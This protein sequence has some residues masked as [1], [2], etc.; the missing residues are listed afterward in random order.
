MRKAWKYPL[1]SSSLLIAILCFGCGSARKLKDNELLLK[2]NIVHASNRDLNRDEINTYIRQKPNRKLFFFYPFYLEIYNLVNQDKL[3]KHK[4][5]RDDR[6][7]LVNE[8]RR[9]RNQNINE[10]RRS[11]NKP[12]KPLH[13]K[14]K[15]RLTFRE[16]LVNI[17]EEPTLFDSTLANRSARQ[18]SLY[19]NNK[20]YFNNT[21]RDSIVIRNNKAKVYYL[22]KTPKAYKIRKIKYD[23]DDPEAAYYVLADSSN[24]LLKPGQNVDSDVL[25]K[26]RDRITKVL[27]NEGYFYFSKEY[28]YYTLDSALHTRQADITIGL[29]KMSRPGSGTDSMTEVNHLRYTIEH[30]YILTDY[31]SKGADTLTRD[32]L[33][34]K[35]GYSFLYANK[36]HYK[37]KIISDAIYFHEGE[38]YQDQKNDDTYKRLV[39]LKAF[40]QVQIEYIPSKSSPP[41]ELDCFIRLTP[42]YKQ[43]IS[44]GGE[45]TNTGGNLGIN[46]SIVYQNKNVLKGAEVFELKAKGALELQ[47]LVVNIGSEQAKKGLLPFN[48]IELGPEFNLYVP[49]ALFPFNLF[50]I[51]KSANPKTTFTSYYNFQ[52][53]PDYTRSIFN[54]GYAYEW[55]EGKYK[56]H[57]ILPFEVNLVK[58]LK[59]DPAFQTYLNSYHDFYLQSRYQNHVTTDTRWTYTFTN[60]EIKKKKDYIFFRFDLESSGTLLRSLAE[61]SNSL[62]L[63][64]IPKDADGS[65][66]IEQI[67]FS[68]YIKGGYDLRLYKLLTEYNRVIFRTFAGLGVPFHNLSTLPFEKSYYAGGPNDVRAF[69]ARSL[70]PGSYNHADGSVYQLGDMQMEAN[71]EYRYK[72]FKMLNAAFFV[73]AGNIW[74]LKNDPLRTGGNF[75]LNRFYKEFA[76]GTGVGVRLDFDF[77]ILRLDAG[78]P[79]RDPSYAD[80]KRWM[81]DKQ[82]FLKTNLNFGIGYPF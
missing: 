82:P 40:K 58:L 4:Q 57:T 65:Y 20:G 8:R 72:I 26:E 28:I 74:L 9:I 7:E 38:L 13:L 10:K 66:R 76:I 37:T 61:L 18:I 64:Q 23:L 17:G 15:D 75:D 43:S 35:E 60:Q 79:L 52:Q 42:V 80:G 73:D 21:V 30:I 78:V 31:S 48:T 6:I 14:S 45:A 44:T 39:Q 69:Q 71:L 47:K 63:I 32:T 41:G 11:R 50:F 36:L 62:N 46:G 12:E 56:K 34:T 25:Q 67:K 1:V 81:F 16:W 59:I 2:R 19:L 22:I 53:R 3:K 70:G 24:C 68:Q 27:K 51:G 55:R 33:K 54:M 77:F 5:R 29:K 49:R